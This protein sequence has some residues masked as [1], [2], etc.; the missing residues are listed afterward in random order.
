MSTKAAVDFLSTIPPEDLSTVLPGYQAR[1]AVEVG[2]KG[3]TLTEAAREEGVSLPVMRK[4]LGWAAA[5][6]ERAIEEA[7]S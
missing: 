6:M 2:H 4:T 1:R 7:N 3:L 5:N